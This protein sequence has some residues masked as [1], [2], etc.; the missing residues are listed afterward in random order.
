MVMSLRRRLAACVLA[1]SVVALGAASASAQTLTTATLSGSVSASGIS[2]TVSSGTGFTVGNFLF[3]DRETMQILAVFGSTVTVQRGFA[4]AATT[5]TNGATVYTG[6]PA[7]FYRQDPASA[8]C[9]P[10]SSANPYINITSGNTFVCT[11]LGVWVQN[12]SA[13]SGGGGGSGGGSGDALTTGSLAQFASTTSGELRGVLSDETGTGVS[14]FST[15]PAL[16]TPDLGTPSALTLTNATGLPISTGVSGLGSGVATFLGAASSAN[17]AAAITNETGTGVAV[18]STS[19]ILTT[20]NLGTPSAVVLTSATGLPLTTGVTGFLPIG[21][22]CTATN[23]DNTHFLRGD[24]TWQSI[25]GGGDALTSSPLSQFASTTS[26]QLAGVLSNE[27]GSG[28]AVF[29]TSPALTTP[30]LGT[31]SAATLTNATGLPVS[32]GISGLAS[33]AATFLATSTSAN[34]AALITN[35]TGSGAAVFATSPTLVTPVLGAATGTSV[36][37]SSFASASGYIAGYVTK[38]GTYTATSADSTIECLTNAFTVNLPT[39]AGITGRIYTIKNLQTAN[40]CTVDPSGAETIDGSSTSAVTNGALTV[41]SDGTNWRSL[42]SLGVPVTAVAQGDLL[43]G[44]AAAT[45]SALTKSATTNAVLCN[46]GTSNNPAWCVTAANTETLTNK[47][48]DAEGTGNTI[49]LPTLVMF[50][51]GNCQNATASI[52]F[53]LPTTL[54]ATATCQGGAAGGHAAMGTAKFVN[55]EIDEVQGHFPLPSDW[56][57][58][59]DVS[60]DWNAVSITGNDVVWQIK[61][62]CVATAEAP[63]GTSYNT[64]AFTAVTNKTTTLQMNRSTK[65]GITTT[66]CAAGETAFFIILRDTAAAG[67]TLDQDVQLIAATFTVRRAI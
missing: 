49:T 4:G 55:T 58:A 56:T 50:S 63:S 5:H 48:L 51:G 44:S 22:I 13:S 42:G 59:I 62:G 35:E 16:T 11:A 66:G 61:F 15:S 2:V 34:L 39:A 32:T 24:C 3:V 45:L 10:A 67:D 64:T 36:V 46:T 40:A 14:V 25:A 37:L 54:G 29:A 9:L 18:F 12:P 30:D 28:L 27:T 23:A 21:N 19:P 43:Y 47:T 38:T 52:G 20:P 31:P 57:G 7:Q 8:S 17:L 53:D 1:L 6:P 26:A 65:T 41:Q 33:G 60:L